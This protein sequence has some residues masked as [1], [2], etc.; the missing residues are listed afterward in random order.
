MAATDFDFSQT[1]LQIV[2]QAHRIIGALALG[3]SLTTDQGTQ[4]VEA[5]NQIVKGLQAEHIFLWTLKN[6]SQTLSSATAS[7]LLSS[8]PPVLA[9]EK[10]WLR[11]SGNDTPL[12]V[13]GWRDYQDIQTKAQA[14]SLYVWPV[15][16]S[17]L[18]LYYLASTKAKD[19]D[20]DASTGDFPVKWLRALTYTLAADLADQYGVPL[21]E[22][23]LLSAK[24]EDLLTK[25]K[26]SDR[27]V[28]ENSFVRG[29][30]D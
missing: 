24:A 25:A 21:S 16:T 10:A 15:P 6:I 5:L 4:G 26:K 12:E 3:E 18:A 27:E 14:P 19:F 23:N 29:T 30:Y 17:T 20:L 28:S 13:I 1:R 22:R 9:V 7:Y 8:D 11:I 2:Q